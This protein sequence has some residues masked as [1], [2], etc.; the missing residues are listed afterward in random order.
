MQIERLINFS[1]PSC[2]EPYAVPGSF[3]VPDTNSD[4]FCYEHG[5]SFTF[6]CRNKYQRIGN[7]SLG[8]HTVTCGKVY[9]GLWDLGVLRCIGK[10]QR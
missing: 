6:Q 5:C 1:E 7:S 3:Y 8:N 9:D 4:G 10:L 2:G